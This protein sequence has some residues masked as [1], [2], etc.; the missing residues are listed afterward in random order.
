MIGKALGLIS[1]FFVMMR[2]TFIGWN[3]QRAMSHAASIAFYTI[4]SLAPLLILTVSIAGSVYSQD[5]VEWRIVAGIEKQAG[6]PAAAYVH[7]IMVNVDDLQHSRLATGASVLLLI[8]GGS[9][10]FLQLQSSINEMWG[11]AP[12]QERI[13]DSL[14]A[15][16]RSR[17]LSAGI[18]VA[19]GYLV[20]IALTLSTFL[21]MIP[22]S[23]MAGAAETVDEVAPFV[24]VWSSP[25]VYTVLFAFTFKT[26]P[27]AKI[28]WRDLWVG[29]ALTA[30][31]FWVGNKFIIYY[32]SNSIVM[33]VY[34]AASSVV[35]FLVWVYYT[36]WIVL[37]GASFI[38]VYAET[39]GQPIRPYDFMKYRTG[40]NYVSDNQN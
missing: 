6:E 25:I 32:L 27:Q 29:S 5:D 30:L 13:R 31:L 22:V 19:M 34:G 1:G 11:I 26:L 4:F 38:R 2:E 17:L 28:R 40:V 3:R 18:V 39:C 24:R 23:V 7:D 8:W 16:L 14:Y 33:S 15:M 37:F 36:A 20:V 35:V 9:A 21:A 12:N 10:M